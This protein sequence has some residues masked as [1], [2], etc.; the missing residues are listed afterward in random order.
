MKWLKHLLGRPALAESWTLPQVE[1]VG[2]Q[3]GPFEQDL[4]TRWKVV[5]SQHPEVQRAYLALAAYNQGE[6]HQPVL[7]IRS[8]GEKDVRLVHELA[9]PFKDLFARDCALD[10][11]FLTAEKE[12]QVRKVCRAFHS[13]I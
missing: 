11:M 4:K 5:L 13:T 12:E 6:S 9:A 10:I 1:F 7:C 2:E 3:D 8:S